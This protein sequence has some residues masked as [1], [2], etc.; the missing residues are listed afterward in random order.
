MHRRG[1]SCVLREV[2]RR[3][4][5]VSRYCRLPWSSWGGGGGGGEGGEEGIP[6][7]EGRGR[8]GGYTGKRGR[9]AEEGEGEGG[10]EGEGG[11]GGGGRLSSPHLQLTP[12]GSDKAGR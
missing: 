3:P 6:V 7:R 4:M 9:S 1:P 8:G 12:G 2:T 5:E 10:W 11:E